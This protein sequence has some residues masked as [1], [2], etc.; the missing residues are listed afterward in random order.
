[1]A[2]RINS[3]SKAGTKSKQ[4]SWTECKSRSANSAQIVAQIQCI[5]PAQIRVSNPALHLPEFDPQFFED[6]RGGKNHCFLAGLRLGAV[7]YGGPSCHGTIIRRRKKFKLIRKV[8]DFISET[9]LL[10][11]SGERF[12]SG[13]VQRRIRS[14]IQSQP[15][16]SKSCS[17]TTFS[18]TKSSKTKEYSSF[19]RV[20]WLV[21]QSGECF[22]SGNWE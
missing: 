14:C 7:R 5:D 22:R 6:K 1:M 18:K 2:V 17:E 13:T 10:N 21:E 11:Y 16:P 19:R 8:E 3:R 12:R 15:L 4:T 20:D 9:D